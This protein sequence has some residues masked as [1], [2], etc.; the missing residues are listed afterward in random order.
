MSPNIIAILERS[1]WTSKL[2]QNYTMLTLDKT[3]IITI[4]Y[5]KMQ[6]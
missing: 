1:Y 6:N 2:N 4:E 3:K 5:V